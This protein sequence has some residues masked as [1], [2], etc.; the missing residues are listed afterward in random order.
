MAKRVVVELVD[1]INGQSGP[2]Q[3]D[4]TSTA[5]TTKSTSSTTGPPR[6][7]GP[8]IAAARPTNSNGKPGRRQDDATAPPPPP[9][10]APD[11]ALGSRQRH[12]TAGRGRIPAATINAYDDHIRSRT[13]GDGGG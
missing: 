5:P 11:P 4:S 12:T 9:R 13:T 8:Y 7:P 1:D 6:A 2:P 3:H 10:P